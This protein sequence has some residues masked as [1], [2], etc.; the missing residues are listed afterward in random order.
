LEFQLVKN[1]VRNRQ[2]SE[3]RNCSA[4]HC[5]RPR[6]YRRLNAGERLHASSIPAILVVRA[7]LLSSRAPS[8]LPVPRSPSSHRERTERTLARRASRR[9][10][11]RRPTFTTT[12]RS[13][14]PGVAQPHL[15]PPQPLPEPVRVVSRPN[16]PSTE[17]QT[18]AAIADLRRAP[19]PTQSSLFRTSSAQNRATVS[20]IAPYSPSPT[21]SPRKSAAAAAESQPR[22]RGRAGRRPH[23]PPAPPAP[24]RA[25]PP[26]A[27]GSP[28]LP[29]ARAARSLR[30]PMLR[31]PER[32]R[33]TAR[34]RS[35]LLCARLRAAPHAP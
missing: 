16:R 19:P 28:G 32:P 6:P 33:A 35:P 12:P 18:T 27:L 4:R 24:P 8:K 3:Q 23:T 5:A 25:P 22:H 30:R 29:E 7:P 11:S 31:R 10:S 9:S 26:R 1:R 34:R 15:A 21:L 20:S 17:L 14:A 2:T 13:I